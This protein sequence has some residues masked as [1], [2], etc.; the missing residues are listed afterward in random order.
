[1]TLSHLADQCPLPFGVEGS[2]GIPWREELLGELTESTVVPAASGSTSTTTGDQDADVDDQELEDVGLVGEDLDELDR[3]EVDDFIGS[4]VEP[5][6]NPDDDDE[7]QDLGGP[8]EEE[9][10]CKANKELKEAN[11][12]AAVLE[13]DLTAEEKETAESV[14]A[15]MLPDGYTVSRSSV[16]EEE[17][18]K[19]LIGKYIMYRTDKSDEWCLGLV[20][21]A[22]TLR[23]KKNWNYQVQFDLREPQSLTQVLLLHTT[24]GMDYS[25]RWFLVE[26]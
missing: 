15:P 10:A 22:G 12:P 24:Y 8:N 26:K 25:S 6:Q 4:D 16:S 2:K 7:V 19:G 11:D 21:R 5:D 14:I 13:Q 1:M 17:L 20:R 9:A 23:T 18:E 3:G